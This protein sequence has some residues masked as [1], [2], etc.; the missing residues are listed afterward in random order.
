MDLVVPAF[1]SDRPQNLAI[2]S[3]ILFARDSAVVEELR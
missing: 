2:A 3:V 1:P